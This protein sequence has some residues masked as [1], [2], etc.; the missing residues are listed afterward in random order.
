[1]SAPTQFLPGIFVGDQFTANN[2]KFFND[3]NIVRVVNC[4]KD[5][6][7]YFPS[8]AEYFRIPVDDS[9]DEITN[10]I[11]AAYLVRAVQFVLEISPRPGK[12][13][14]IHCHMGVSRSCT[15]AAAVLRTCCVPTIKSALSTLRSKRDM[16]FFRGMHVNF[17]KA[18]Y[19]T[20]PI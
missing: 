12:A 3:N 9:P 1:M 15:V 8:K 10:N 20:F 17:A 2:P 4:T 13:V 7:F 11:M 14:L 16:A 19:K 18:L 6:P 5:L